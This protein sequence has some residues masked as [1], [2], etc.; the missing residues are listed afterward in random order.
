[1]KVWREDCGTRKS[2]LTDQNT[3]LDL[4]KSS[5]TTQV[6]LIQS[7]RLKQQPHGPKATCATS[8][9]SFDLLGDSGKRCI[10]NR[11]HILLQ[12]HHQQQHNTADHIGRSEDG[13]WST[14]TGL[15]KK[16][17]EIGARDYY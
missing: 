10:Q 8:T 15:Q 1:M 16:E 4:S 9:P 3:G 17:T 6:K 13:V 12:Y 2:V 7:S 11:P 5:I 14:T